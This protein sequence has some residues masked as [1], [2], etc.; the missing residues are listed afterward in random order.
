MRA[1][2]HDM[3]DIKTYPLGTDLVNDMT[4]LQTADRVTNVLVPVG[5]D[6]QLQLSLEVPCCGQRAVM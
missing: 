6:H 2:K 3:P 4:K 1:V 5:Q